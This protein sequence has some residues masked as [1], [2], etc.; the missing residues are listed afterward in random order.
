VRTRIL[1]VKLKNIRSYIDRIIVFP[2]SGTTV[3]YGDNGTGK[4]SI[5][6]GINY[7]LFGLPR[8]QKGSDPFIGFVSPYKDDLL[9]AG[10]SSA[11][12][13]VLVRH[14]D[15]L[16]LIERRLN[17]DRGGKITILSLAD[18]T[19][20]VESSSSYS[21]EDLTEKILEVL[22][23]REDPRKGRNTYIFNNVMYVPQFNIHQTLALDD[24]QRR[25]L[26][27]KVLGLEK[28]MIMLNN[29]EKIAKG[30]NSV[31]G[32]ELH[33][34]NKMIEDRRKTLEKINVS[35]VRAKLS[36][37][38]GR[39]EELEKVLSELRKLRDSLEAEKEGLSVESNKLSVRM[40]ELK[41]KIKV[42]N[43]KEKE[44]LS[45]REKLSKILLEA[46]LSGVEDVDK[47]V[48]ELQTRK[49]GLEGERSNIVKKLE[50][51]DEALRRI[52]VD[53]RNVLGRVLKL[54]AEAENLKSRVREAWNEVLEMRNVVSQ[55]VCPLC[56]QS[57]THEHGEE[58]VRGKISEVREV[59]M[60]IVPL[61]KELWSGKSLLLR[62]YIE[63]E[64]VKAARNELSKRLEEVLRELREVDVAIS[65]ISQVKE[66][67]DEISRLEQEVSDKPK[68]LEELRACEEEYGKLSRRVE[69]LRAKLG[70]IKEEEVARSKE[71]G[72][73]SEQINNLE[74]R[75]EEYSELSEE[76]RKLELRAS[77]LT[78]IS[79]YLLNHVYKG[80]ETIESAVRGI[81]HERFN[82][83]FQEY[84]IKLL[85]DQELIEA[86]VS[87]FKPSV[88]VRV[89]ALSE[90]EISQPSGA[91]LTALGLAYRL[92]LNRVVRD[93]NKELRDSVLILDEPTLGFSPERVEKLRELIE[94]I[95]SNLGRAQV[96][97]VTHDERL[98]E[99]GD[100]R[101]R[102]SIDRSKN[103]TI[104]DYEECVV[105]EENVDFQSYKSFIEGVI[106][107]H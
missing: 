17:G 70:K 24:K 93:L 77:F 62:L 21:S 57:I 72:E 82:E 41:N 90:R 94:S 8:G 107:K 5:L 11:M 20:R 46:G 87:D 6:L 22:G 9:R 103:E 106:S 26:V 68:V 88:R 4:T 15:K 7:A 51:L 16:I 44:L 73:V 18:G 37:L 39:R 105:G 83:Y 98:L 13:K 14:K 49:S 12:V 3:I 71:L 69:E 48:D 97:L 76:L 29:I 65:K 30:K 19:A 66:L 58:L 89:G 102:L 85:E 79:D 75:L 99:V 56:R 50:E 33:N 81:A 60:K 100:C 38:R 84:F 36:E 78:K 91:Q 34:L 45:K 59:A 86:S 2:P 61:I 40:G 35:E 92:A 32:S 67:Q 27:D 55:G 25:E 42:I 28:Y 31:I 104:V 53:E 64:E 101:I 63:K 96:L 10:A 74:K 52:E 47:L 1:G 95:G 54:E 80:V 23:L 43:E